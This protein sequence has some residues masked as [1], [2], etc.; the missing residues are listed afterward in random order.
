MAKKKEKI[1]FERHPKSVRTHRL[2][3]L[4]SEE[5]VQMVDHYLRKYHITNK[6]RWM[7]ET[8]LQF[9]LRNL[10]IDY[11]TLFDEHDMRR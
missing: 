3:T 6:S 11:P 1:P 2:I 7:R 5:E 10:E 9:I 8:L 4:M